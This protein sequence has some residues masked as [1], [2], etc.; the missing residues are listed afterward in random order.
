MAQAVSKKVAVI[1]FGN[2]GTGV[3]ETLYSKGFTSLE[4]VKVVDL[5][6]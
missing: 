1:G 5:L 6:R 2:I 3:V 4:L